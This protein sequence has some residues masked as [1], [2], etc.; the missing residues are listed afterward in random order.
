[1]TIFE[2]LKDRSEHLTGSNA[3]HWRR[4]IHSGERRPGN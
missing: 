1:V 2:R 3:S 4:Q